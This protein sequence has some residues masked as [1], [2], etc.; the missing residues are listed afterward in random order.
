MANLLPFLLPLSFP[1]IV[2]FLCICYFLFVVFGCMGAFLCVPGLVVDR[3]TVLFPNE[4]RLDDW[5]F[6]FEL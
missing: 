3:L 2:A 1:G 5:S 6:P 4:S